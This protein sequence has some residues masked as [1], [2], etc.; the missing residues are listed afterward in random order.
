MSG[1]IDIAIVGAG[2]AGIAAARRAQDY[3]LSFALLEARDRIGGRCHTDTASLG[4]TWDRGAHWLHSAAVNPLTHMAEALGHPYLR[5]ESFIDRTL[6]LGNRLATRDERADY[7]HAIDAAFDAVDALGEKG[8]DVPVAEAH[9]RGSRW[10]RLIEHL[11]EAISA[12]PPERIS[13]LDLYRYY[14]SGENWPLIRGY[15]ALLEALGAHLPVSLKTPVTGV[16]WSGQGVALET[17]KGTVRAKAAIITVSTNVL[18][19]GLIRFSPVLPSAMQGALDGVPTGVANKVAIKFSRDVFGLPDTSYAS[20]MDERDPARHA[21]SFQ[22]R[23]FGQE[24]AIAYLGG[25]FAEEMEREGEA[26]MIDMA[27][28]ALAEMFG[29]S[30]RGA[31]ERAVATGWGADPYAL[32]AYS[33]ALP[34]HAEDR[35][36][37]AE[38]VGERIFLAGEAVHPSW[39]STVQGAFLSGRDAA[40]RACLAIGHCSC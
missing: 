39:F 13:A 25:R 2:A 18:A 5:R 34:G 33:S 16:D 36:R 12:F 17:P 19:Q 7:Q 27:T 32:G 14:D 23:P 40:E 10:Y 21:L 37:L 6:H 35:L 30:I 28:S 11:H 15:G 22:I 31:V 26:A 20:F 8:L 9:D 38:P 29:S 1:E 24:L 4:V 3:G